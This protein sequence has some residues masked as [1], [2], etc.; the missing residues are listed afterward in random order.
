MMGGGQAQTKRCEGERHVSEWV[1]GVSEKVS[2]TEMHVFRGCGDLRQTM[3]LSIAEC[4][5]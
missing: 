4:S 2:G 3:S 1:G 5:L